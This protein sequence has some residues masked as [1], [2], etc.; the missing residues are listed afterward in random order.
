MLLVEISIADAHCS[1]FHTK[2]LE[3]KRT[4]QMPSPD[5]F[6]IDAKLDLKHTF[7]ACKGLH[8]RE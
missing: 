4:I 8:S 7:L 6:R 1:G 5:V 3:S 2:R